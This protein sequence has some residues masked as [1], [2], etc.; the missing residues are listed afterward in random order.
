MSTSARFFCHSILSRLAPAP[1]MDDFIALIHAIIEYAIID[2]RHQR[3]AWDLLDDHDELLPFL[4]K[5]ICWGQCR[6]DLVKGFQRL[7]GT[8]PHEAILRAV[9]SI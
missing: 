3:E 9:R 2:R 1:G 8:V 7:N 6:P 5:A 4:G